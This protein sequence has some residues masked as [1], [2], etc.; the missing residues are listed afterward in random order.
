MHSTAPRNGH[1][2][3]AAPHGHADVSAWAGLTPAIVLHTIRRAL[4]W[5]APTGV[6]LAGAAVTAVWFVF[7]LQYLGRAWVQFLSNAPRLAFNPDKESGDLYARTQVELIRSPFVLRDVLS[8]PEVASLPEYRGLRDPLEWLTKTVQVQAVGGSELYTVGFK[9]PS[10]NSS[11]ILANAILDSYLAK[12]PEYVNQQSET[13]IKLLE[14]ELQQR[15]EE[16][17]R[18]RENMKQVASNLTRKD[19]TLIANPTDVNLIVES[20]GPIDELNSRLTQL[21]VEQQLGLA[22]KAT[23]TKMLEGTTEETLSEPEIIQAIEADAEVTRLAHQLS[24]LD[25]S[26]KLGEERGL[27]ADHPQMQALRIE[28][29]RLQGLLT[30]RRTK[31]RE[32]VVADLAVRKRQANRAALAQV[33]QKVTLAETSISMVNAQIEQEKERLIKSGDHSLEFSFA[34]QEVIR[35]QEV[36][37]RI[38]DRVTEMKTEMRAPQRVR[39]MR[40]ASDDAVTIAFRPWMFMSAAGGG[41]FL[42]PFVLAVFW[43]NRTRHLTFSEQVAKETHLPVLAE[44]SRVPTRLMSGRERKLGLRRAMF[45]ESIDQLR[46][47]LLLSESAKDKRVFAMVSAVSGEGKSSIA[48]QLALSVARTSNQAVLL[49]DA[50]MRAP[51]QHHVFGID[52][53]NG[54]AEVLAGECKAEDAIVKWDDYVHVL[55]A[56]QL[57]QNPNTLLTNE[58]MAKLFDELR[59]IYPYI[60]IDCPPLLAA[61]EAYVVAREADGAMLCVMRDVSRTL[62][63]RKAF[64]RLQSVGVETVGMVLSGVPTYEY[65]YRYGGYSR[66]YKKYYRDALYENTQ[67][68]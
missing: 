56:G 21:E 49:I 48:S 18:L 54:L 42:L 15:G 64:E 45:E 46:I 8:Q 52:L 67:T 24:S 11:V 59:T 7:P 60:L 34:R 6:L 27:G 30:D 51:S 37:D 43:E 13:T 28:E 41:A 2:A 50:D 17:K 57:A 40:R 63:V 47:S 10:R 62:Q 33:E 61:T 66:Y 65:A 44:V 58:R 16:L 38:A 12:Q 20:H 5:A 3:P 68:Q 14:D 53:T 55:P 36:Y 29:Q 26:R 39:V 25:G 23:L 9:C 19:P 22:E 4:W 35:S 1:A 32:T 31:A